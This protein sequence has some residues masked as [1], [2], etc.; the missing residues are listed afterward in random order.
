M[1]GGHNRKPTRL[2]V[3]EGTARADRLR[4]EPQPRP[5]RPKRPRWLPREARRFWDELA[6]KLE[7]L[8]VLCETDGPAF[9]LCAVHYAIA[10]EAAKVLKDQGVIVAD[11]EHPAGEKPAVRKHPLL[12]VLRDHSAA[13]RAYSSLFGLSPADR[14]RLNISVEED[15]NSLEYL[16]LSRRLP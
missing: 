8:G 15:S 7:K 5:I 1:R 16:W 3:L 13:F 11:P 10:V 2:K 14:G 9:A 12:S 6:P 4:N